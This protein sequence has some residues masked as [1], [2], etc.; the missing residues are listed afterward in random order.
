MW[1][2]DACVARVPVHLASNLREHHHPH[3]TGNPTIYEPDTHPYRVR[4]GLVPALDSG[5]RPVECSRKRVDVESILLSTSAFP[6]NSLRSVGLHSRVFQPTE[7][8]IQL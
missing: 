7:Y 3:P 8:T 4:A 5:T 2:W 6:L 1:G